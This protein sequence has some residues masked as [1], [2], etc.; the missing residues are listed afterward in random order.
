MHKYVSSRAGLVTIR[1][2]NVGDNKEAYSE[3]STIVYP[4]PDASV[5]ATGN[6]TDITRVSGGTEPASRF[7]S[8]LTLVW[9]TYG[10]IISLPIALGAY[11]I[12]YKKG[13][14]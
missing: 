10:V 5:A 1:I 8:P 6:G 11:I 14:I 9:I 2:E 12:M 4:N 3:F 7:L 13:I